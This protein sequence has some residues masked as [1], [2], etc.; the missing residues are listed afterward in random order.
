[1]QSGWAI[2]AMLAAGIAA[3]VLDRFGWRVLFLFG[4][5][6]AVAAF[7]IRRNV[8]EPLIWRQRTAP[9]GTLVDIFAPQ[10]LRRTVVA[11]LVASSV[12]IAYW[13]LTSWLPAFLASPVSRGGAGL[14]L[15]KSALWLVIVQAGAFA[16]YVSF[17]WIADRFG[18][19][20]SFTLFMVGAAVVVPVFAF[21]ARNPITLLT[22]GP[23]VGY[24][25]HGYF[26][27]FGAM[28]AELFPTRIRA[29]AQGFC[30]NAGRIA[31][32]AA[33]YT[34][35]AL[36]SSRLGVGL[37]FDALFFAVGGVLIWFLPETRG[38]EL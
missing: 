32:A 26:S 31:S 30:Y 1:M 13:G 27:L 14:T 8:D 11:T 33:P 5:L 22:I 3:L 23:L 35:G 29:T 9:A 36:A 24:F 17:G 21:G 28:L 12:L 19:R 16:G 15:T 2:G 7:F 37:A 4:A 25:G 38:A 6:P 34:I 18:R 10:F 20:L